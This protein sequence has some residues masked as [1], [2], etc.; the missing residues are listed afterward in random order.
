[1]KTKQIIVALLILTIL[2]SVLTIAKSYE[3]SE[4]NS[5][6]DY[7]ISKLSSEKTQDFEEFSK[8]NIFD[9]INFAKKNHQD[10]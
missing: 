2:I 5:L 1:M 3:E 10:E 9:K 8:L 6:K 4:S 7:F